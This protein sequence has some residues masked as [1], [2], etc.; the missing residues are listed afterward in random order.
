M[1][2]KWK[3]RWE[4]QK[5]EVEQVERMEQKWQKRDFTDFIK[6]I[7]FWLTSGL[8]RNIDSIASRFL[9]PTAGNTGYTADTA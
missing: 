9:D 3:A 5:K 7:R 8:S 2:R 4:M 1:E 6:S